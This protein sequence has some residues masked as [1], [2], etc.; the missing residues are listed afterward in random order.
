M[1]QKAQDA[2]HA[3]AATAPRFVPPN[4]VEKQPDCIKVGDC[5]TGR[6]AVNSLQ[7]EMR[8]YQVASLRWMSH[9]YDHGVNCILGDEMGLGKTLQ[10]IAFLAHL[11]YER[12]VDGPFLVVVP[13]SVMSSWMQ[14]L[15]RWCPSFKAIKLHSCD[16]KE[17]QRLKQ[18]VVTSPGAFDVAVTTYEMIHSRD[19]SPLI[20]SL[21]W[22]TLVLDEGT[23][24]L[25]GACLGGQCK[26]GTGS[27]SHAASL[28]STPEGQHQSAP[29]SKAG[30]AHQLPP[31]RDAGLLVPA[32]SAQ[33]FG[34]H[35][36][37]AWTGL[38]HQ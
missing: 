4:A 24:A 15:Q 10:T 25:N 19:M 13:L 8:D 16:P 5:W 21:Y 6:N 35:A 9:M 3:A 12:N 1:N 33:E 14:E 34:C 37:D 32:P 30:D 11:R 18:E 38:G 2:M 20:R 28:P 31:H 27:P 7:A 36:Q 23:D 17:V 29:A 22:R 26:A